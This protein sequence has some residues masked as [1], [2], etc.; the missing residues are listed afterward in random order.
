MGYLW[1]WP[2]KRKCLLMDSGEVGVKWKAQ[3]CTLYSKSCQTRMPMT[4]SAGS[5]RSET[6][7]QAA[8]M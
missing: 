4:N 7:Y 3:R 2:W 6:P 1:W 8:E 5:R